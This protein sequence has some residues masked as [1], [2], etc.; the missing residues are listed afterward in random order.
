ML[1]MRLKMRW[2]RLNIDWTRNRLIRFLALEGQLLR[3]MRKRR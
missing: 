2:L 3:E 1:Y